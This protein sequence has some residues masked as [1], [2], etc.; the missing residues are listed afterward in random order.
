MIP[1][2]W[3][4]H[5]R[6]SDGELVGYLVPGE[7]G[8]WT[9]VTVFGLPVDGPVDLDDAERRLDEV[10]LSHLAQRWLLDLPDA[11]P[12]AVQIVE[13]TPSVLTLAS[14]DFGSDVEYGTRF[15]LDV[16]VTEALR[17]A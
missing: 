6:V 3:Q 11:G 9:P 10:G 17:P 16:P 15:T 12:I 2:A 8:T 14:V 13:A 7:S 1:T 4:P 5:R